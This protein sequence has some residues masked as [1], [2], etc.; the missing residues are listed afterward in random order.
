MKTLKPIEKNNAEEQKREDASLKKPEQT[1]IP[2]PPEQPAKPAAP[3]PPAEIP[4]EQPIPGPPPEIPAGPPADIQTEEQTS[5]PPP[6]FDYFQGRL[7]SLPPSTAGLEAHVWFLSFLKNYSPPLKPPFIRVIVD[8]SRIK[9]ELPTSSSLL[10]MINSMDSGITKNFQMQASWIAEIYQQELLKFQALKEKT[11]F[12]NWNYQGVNV[13]TRNDPY[14]STD[15]YTRYPSNQYG[16]E[17]FFPS[18]NPQ[19]SADFHVTQLESELRRKNDEILRRDDQQRVQDEEKSRKTQGEMFELMLLQQDKKQ[20]DDLDR[21][22]KLKEIINPQKTSDDSSNPFF[23]QIIKNNEGLNEKIQRLE[24]SRVEQVAA[25]MAHMRTNMSTMQEENRSLRQNSQN[26][27]MNLD[28]AIQVKKIDFD[29]QIESEK[30]NHEKDSLSTWGN[31]I[32]ESAELLGTGIG[33]G[34]ANKGKQP[35]QQGMPSAGGMQP[36]PTSTGQTIINCPKCGLALE[37]EPGTTFGECPNPECK[38]KMEIDGSGNV[39]LHREPQPPSGQPMPGP[40]QRP[41]VEMR[42]TIPTRP[43][44]PP[45]TFAPGEYLDMPAVSPQEDF[46]IKKKEYESPIPPTPIIEIPAITEEPMPPTQETYLPNI[47]ETSETSIEPQPSALPPQEQD[48]GGDEDFYG[49]CSKCGKPVFETGP[50]VNIGAVE[51]GKPV[52][53]ECWHNGTKP[54]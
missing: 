25:E 48:F 13:E 30:I 4:R 9:N 15:P 22:L 17:R 2:V 41:P 34:F 24:Q 19:T 28:Q 39:L 14:L 53:K 3:T 23:Q 33:K 6:D 40:T 8:H 46:Q 54:V 49:M 52:C 12:Q 1:P 7:P 42:D 21:L 18:G 37:L 32:K 26:A 10:F 11:S 16:Q 29:Y 50:N 35:S 5:S 47:D 36:P 27:G 44:R 45:Q 38:C 20:P 43:P 31:I 51:G